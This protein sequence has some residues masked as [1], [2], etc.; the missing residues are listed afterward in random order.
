MLCSS[1]P[2]P[3]KWP[4]TKL[5]E[6][7][8]F[9]SQNLA[10]P[11]MAAR[12]AKKEIRKR[13]ALGCVLCIVG[14]VTLLLLLLLHGTPSLLLPLNERRFRHSHIKL[15]GR[16]YGFIR[17]AVFY[18]ASLKRRGGGGGGLFWKPD[19]L[20]I[21][22][23]LSLPPHWRW[24][25]SLSLSLFWPEGETE[26]ILHARFWSHTRYVRYTQLCRSLNR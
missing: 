11:T 25:L 12:Q 4:F 16:L 17:G 1:S 20:A 13:Q 7:C 2:F 9:Q 24:V 10:T 6:R 14:T 26:P 23:S 19:L 21:P 5:T 18:S 3:P 8:F 22:P 15:G